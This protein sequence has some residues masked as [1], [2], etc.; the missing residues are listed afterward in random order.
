MDEFQ[1]SSS[2]P[3]VFFILKSRSL[4]DKILIP[5][6]RGPLGLRFDSPENFAISLSATMLSE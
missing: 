6:E 3:L 1:D 2:C 4:V 5:L